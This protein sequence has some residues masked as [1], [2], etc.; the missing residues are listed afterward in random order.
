MERRARE[1]P[2]AFVVAWLNDSL[3]KNLK[4]TSTG[5]DHAEAV[6]PCPMVKVWSVGRL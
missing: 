4:E 2:R 1:S 6:S 5:P 3:E